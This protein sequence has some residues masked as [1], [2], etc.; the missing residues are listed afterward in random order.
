MRIDGYRTDYTLG[1]PVRDGMR[2][3]YHT[4]S[5]P[6]ARLIW[7]CPY[8]DLFYSPDKRPCGEGYKE[9]ALIRMD[10]EYW[11]AEEIASNRLIVNIGED[12]IGWDAWKETNKN[13]YD[14]T[15]SFKREGD[16]IIT[17]MDNLGISITV[18]TTIIEESPEIYVSLTGDQ[19]ALTNIR[20]FNDKPAES[21]EP[22]DEI[23]EN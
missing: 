19:V 9:Y 1:V 23:S 8:V 16:R 14:S 15:V 3:V 5:L 17:V 12:F 20:I 13:G 18:I 7:H 21:E 10:G 2:I 11:E 6:T 22:Q 4:M